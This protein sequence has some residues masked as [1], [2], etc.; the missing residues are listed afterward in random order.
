LFTGVYEIIHR[1]CIEEEENCGM[2]TES[3]R[4]EDTLRKGGGGILGIEKGEVVK[5]NL[6]DSVSDSDRSR[7]VKM[8]QEC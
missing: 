5:R 1:R 7:K 3:R 6:L 2:P 8:E 4:R